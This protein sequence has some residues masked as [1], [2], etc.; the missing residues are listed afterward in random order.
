MPGFDLFKQYWGLNDDE[1]VI[2]DA[3]VADNA[4]VEDLILRFQGVAK[5]ITDK[6]AELS[7]GNSGGDD[8]LHELKEAVILAYNALLSNDTKQAKKILGKFI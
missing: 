8:S 2:T 4:L 7:A 3:S 5:E 1:P 6:V